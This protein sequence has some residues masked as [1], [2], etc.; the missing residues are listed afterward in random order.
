VFAAWA[1]APGIAGI[2]GA[3]IFLITKYGVMRRSNPVK[4]ALYYVP[5][6]FFLSSAML[7]CKLYVSV[8]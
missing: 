3:I 7:A 4:M 5:F 1:I 6:Y 8:N 2:L